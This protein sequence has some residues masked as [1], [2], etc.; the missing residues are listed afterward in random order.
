MCRMGIRA[1]W[2]TSQ[3]SILWCGRRRTSLPFG[4]TFLSAGHWDSTGSKILRN[5][6]GVGAL[7]LFAISFAYVRLSGMSECLIYGTARLFGR[8]AAA[9]RRQFPFLKAARHDVRV[10]W[11]LDYTGTTVGR[12]HE[13]LHVTSV[14]TGLTRIK[15]SLLGHVTCT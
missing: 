11:H 4:S 2:G 8:G 14:L 13:R 5:F 9:Q 12:L 7:R 1:T 6:P 15:P 10:I 3:R